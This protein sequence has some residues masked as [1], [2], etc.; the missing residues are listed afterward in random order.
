MS[1]KKKNKKPY[2]PEKDTGQKAPVRVR[3]AAGDVM[4]GF[5]GN[6]RH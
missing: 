3:I 5:A 6:D 2:E 4:D 1:K